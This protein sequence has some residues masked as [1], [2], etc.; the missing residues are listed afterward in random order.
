LLGWVAGEMLVDDSSLSD[1]VGANASY[2]H[3]V[4]PLLC[5]ALVVVAGKWMQARSSREETAAA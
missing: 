2:L 1:W 3:I 5:A 4:A